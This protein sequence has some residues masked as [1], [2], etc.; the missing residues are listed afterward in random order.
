MPAFHLLTCLKILTPLSG[1]TFH[2]GQQNIHIKEW[3]EYQNSYHNKLGGDFR[4]GIDFAI[5]IIVLFNPIH[6][7]YWDCN[8]LIPFWIIII[9][10][11]NSIC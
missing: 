2:K 5:E 3:P 9:S 4:L 7:A 11:Y 10:N 6:R 1:H 8:P